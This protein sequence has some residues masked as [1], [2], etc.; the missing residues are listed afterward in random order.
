MMNLCPPKPILRLFRDRAVLFKLVVI[1]QCHETAEWEHV[2]QLHSWR[3]MGMGT[4]NVKNSKHV[5][6]ITKYPRSSSQWTY[7]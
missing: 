3:L 4:V 7:V 1:Q 5:V 2:I 6:S